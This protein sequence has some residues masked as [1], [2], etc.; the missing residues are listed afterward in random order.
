MLASSASLP[1]R[2]LPLFGC[3][4]P[5]ESGSTLSDNSNHDLPDNAILL[6]AVLSM[7]SPSLPFS[8][9]PKP[10]ESKLEPEQNFGRH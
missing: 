2:N 4:L 6:D 7:E 3:L 8:V 10:F 5:D 1:D 9:E